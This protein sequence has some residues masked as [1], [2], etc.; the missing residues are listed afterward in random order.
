MRMVISVPPRTIPYP[1]IP[2]ALLVAM[3]HAIEEAWKHLIG[4]CLPGGIPFSASDYA[5]EDKVT[6]HLEDILNRALGNCLW[7]WFTTSL[8]ETVVRDGK[9]CNYN[10]LHPDKMPDLVFRPVIKPPGSDQNYGV[11]IE[12]K[13]V[14]SG[15]TIGDYVTK[16]LKRFI[17]GDYS[18]CMPQAIMIGYICSKSKLPGGIDNY[19]QRKNLSTSAKSCQPKGKLANPS[20]L[21]NANL[22]DVFVSEHDRAFTIDGTS[23]GGI[24]VYHIW[25]TSP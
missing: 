1:N 22:M 14:G 25:L 16:G 10:S 23:P 17:I 12:C 19:F 9:I 20:I 15:K 13:V 21:S 2:N 7:P 8:F 3:M 6:A 24:Y 5:N 4:H 18:W 11:F